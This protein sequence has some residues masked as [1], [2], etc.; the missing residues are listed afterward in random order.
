MIKHYVFML[1]IYKTIEEIHPII[2]MNLFHAL[3]GNLKITSTI[4]I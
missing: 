4:M 1:T 2:Y 3:T